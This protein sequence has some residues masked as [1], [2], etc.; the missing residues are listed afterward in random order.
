MDEVALAAAL[1]LVSRGWAEAAAAIHASSSD[2]DR[3]P[4]D[5]A[6]LRAFDR[7]ATKGLT[8]AQAAQVFKD[9]GLDPRAFGS[10]VRH[11]WLI[12]E[13][14]RRYLSPK[15]RNWAAEKEAEMKV[16]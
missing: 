2:E 15:G 4:R 7:P 5:V 9:H 16:G 6:V 10:W 13:D 8:R 12:R 11:G 14:D 1:R 3:T